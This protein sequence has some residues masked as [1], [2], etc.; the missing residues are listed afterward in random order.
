MQNG[1][2]VG[3]GGI[4]N[5][6]AFLDRED[7]KAGMV[8][9]EKAEVTGNDT[10]G[11]GG[12]L[13]DL[14]GDMTVKQSIVA[15]NLALLAGGGIGAAERGSLYLQEAQLVDNGTVG[16]GG[17]MALALGVIANVDKSHITDSKAGVFGGGVFNLLSAVTFR[18]SSISGNIAG[19]SGAGIFNVLGD[20]DLTASKVTENRSTFKPGGVFSALGKV[21]VD[22]KSA[23]KG[24]DPTNCQGS[25]EPIE[26]CFG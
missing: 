1:A 18:D 6:A 11:F 17:G 10:L 21:T 13:F 7:I 4:A 19:F 12:G 15:R 8:S 25:P 9:V 24:N 16:D 22:N 23:I 26:N 5:G 3:G 20:V 14:G 2:T